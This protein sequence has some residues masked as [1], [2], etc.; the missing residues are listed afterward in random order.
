MD[1]IECCPEAEL[2]VDP[3]ET[4]LLSVAHGAMLPQEP[5]SQVGLL[6]KGQGGGL[7]S[8]CW[9]AGNLSSGEACRNH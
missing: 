4:K 3:K 1:L 6:F 9:P 8:A 5:S 7:G 2:M